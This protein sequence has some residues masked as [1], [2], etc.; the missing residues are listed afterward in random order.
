MEVVPWVLDDKVAVAETL[1]YTFAVGATGVCL[2]TVVFAQFSALFSMRLALRGGET[3]VEDTI[4][5]IRG[6]YQL[7]LLMLIIGVEMFL[8]CIPFLCQLKGVSTTNTIMICLVDFPMCFFVIYFYRR[9]SGHHQPSL[10]I[11]IYICIHCLFQ[12]K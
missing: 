5:N 8:F 12:Q 9:V 11:Y 4:A 2:L 10:Y 6:E 7:V 3:S 1:Y